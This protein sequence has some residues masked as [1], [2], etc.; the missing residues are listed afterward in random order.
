MFHSLSTGVLTVAVA[1]A[2]GLALTLSSGLAAIAVL[3]VIE[4]SAYA[5]GVFV[6]SILLRY[7][8]F[9]NLIG[10]IVGF[11]LLAIAGVTTPLGL[12]PRAVQTIALGLPLSHDL[13]SLREVLGAGDPGVFLPLVAQELL[14]AAAY[15]ALAA[16][17]IALFL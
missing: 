6:G 16:I 10:N 15:A 14:I 3:I 12:L 13:L 2:L 4:L 11:S 8:A 7:P 5:L 9:G 17:S 1:A